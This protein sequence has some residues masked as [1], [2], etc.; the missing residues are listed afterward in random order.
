MKF[1]SGHNDILCNMAIGG[2]RCPIVFSFDY[3]VSVNGKHACIQY[4]TV[5]VTPDPSNMDLVNALLYAELFAPEYETIV[6]ARSRKS[7][8]RR[9]RH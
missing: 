7:M 1:Y 5:N 8:L 3:T 9:S 2:L 4:G 6:K